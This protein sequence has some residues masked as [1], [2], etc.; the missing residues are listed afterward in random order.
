MK[1]IPLYKHEILSLPAEVVSEKLSTA[2][3]DELRVLLAVMLERE[4]TVSELAAKLDMTENA[5]RR[6][7]S[8]W[9]SYGALTLESS[10]DSTMTAAEKK[11]EVMK[12]GKKVMAAPVLPHRRADCQLPKIFGMPP[13]RFFRCCD[14]CKYSSH[15]WVLTRFPP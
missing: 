2:T 12:D 7:I 5:L 6:A 9:E 8:A 10:A 14:R 15:P 4:F 11:R 13:G 1:I 3:A